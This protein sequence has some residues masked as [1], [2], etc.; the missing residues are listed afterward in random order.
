MHEVDE[1][2]D[3]KNRPQVLE[4]N[5]V[6]CM[7]IERPVSW[8]DALALMDRQPWHK[9]VPLYVHP[10]LG[11]LVWEA[12]EQRWDSVGHKNEPERDLWLE[13]CVDGLQQ[14]DCFP[15]QT[16]DEIR[17]EIIAKFPGT[18]IEE[19]EAMGW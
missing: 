10:E 11:G 17:R 1:D 4:E 7:A 5:S 13:V 9:L 2:Y 19:L 6:R 12:Y 14:P 15:N 18:T 8:V 16:L 3:S